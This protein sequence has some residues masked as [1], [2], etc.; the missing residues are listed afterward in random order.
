MDATS[1]GNQE[2]SGCSELWSP[3]PRS[4]NCTS[5]STRAEAPTDDLR[6][7]PLA[8]DLIAAVP[9]E[10]FAAIPE[11]G[12][13]VTGFKEPLLAEYAPPQADPTSPHFSRFKVEG[14]ALDRY[15]PYRPA[16]P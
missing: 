5:A 9:E 4:S 13:V 2:I 7:A 14:E 1:I 16:T 11:D 15:G 10:L 12:V 3:I 8:A 6:I